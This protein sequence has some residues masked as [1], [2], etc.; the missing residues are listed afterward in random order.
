MKMIKKVYSY[1]FF[2]PLIVGLTPEF[3]CGVARY[4]AATLVELVSALQEPENTVSFS[5]KVFTKADCKKYLGRKKIIRKGYQPVQI[6]LVNN[7]SHSFNFSLGAFSF[8][9]ISAEEM[10]ERMDFSTTKR[11]AGWGVGSLFFS[12]SFLLPTAIE[13]TVSGKESAKLQKD[14]IKKGL[15]N[16]VIKPYDVLNG[17]IF[18]EKSSFNPHFSFTLR[19]GSNGKKYTFSPSKTSFEINHL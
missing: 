5:Y 3:L 9:C 4:K 12:K 11:M 2:L 14:F 8:P 18:V 6:T 10:A 16:T 7:T 15:S 17:L 19:N 13:A 1:W